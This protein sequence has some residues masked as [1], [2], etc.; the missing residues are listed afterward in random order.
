MY[1]IVFETCGTSLK[2]L[3]QCNTVSKSFFLEKQRGEL[4][5]V[6]NFVAVMFEREN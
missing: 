4:K 6:G 2:K 1:L 3:C 5:S